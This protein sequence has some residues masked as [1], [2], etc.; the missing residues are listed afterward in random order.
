MNRSITD[1]FSVPLGDSAAHP[2]RVTVYQRI[3]SAIEEG[4]LPPQSLVPSENQLSELLGVSRTVVREALMLLAEDGLVVTRR[5]IGRFVSDTK[6]QA[7]AERALPLDRLLADPA[8][9]DITVVRLE[10]HLDH[11]D[12]TFA[13]PQLDVP[14]GTPVLTV[15]S[16][17]SLGGKP[18]AYL[19]EHLPYADRGPAELRVLVERLLT[20]AEAQATNV[21]ETTVLNALLEAFPRDLTPTG[22]R[23]AP[24]RLGSSR[25]QLL[26]AGA[27]D[28]AL[29]LTQIMS[30]GETPWYLAKCAITERVG[31]V[32][33]AQTL[34]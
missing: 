8:V 7:G 9:K 26:D 25:A 18:I 20:E 10:T 34:A 30:R 12:A 14:A 6:P 28:P 13:S 1:H 3:A 32:S 23:L 31:A 16:V 4:I 17:L 33:L 15:E 29:I 27:N 11:A 19:L 24:A 2:M 21:P 22:V 5:G